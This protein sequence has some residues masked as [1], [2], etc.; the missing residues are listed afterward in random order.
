MSSSSSQFSECNGLYWDKK[1]EDFDSLVLKG[2]SGKDIKILS[3]PNFPPY[4]D[5]IL[6]NQKDWKR[7]FEKYEYP[8]N[9]GDGTFFGL[10]RSPDPL[11]LNGMQYKPHKS[12]VESLVDLW[13]KEMKVAQD[14]NKEILSKTMYSGSPIKAEAKDGTKMMPWDKEHYLHY[15]WKMAV[16]LMADIFDSCEGS[17][18]YYISD[19]LGSDACRILDGDD[20]DESLN[21]P[22]DAFKGRVFEGRSPGKPVTMES[23]IEALKKMYPSDG[24]QA[25]KPLNVQTYING[26]AGS[27]D[28]PPS[29]QPMPKQD[30]VPA[31]ASV[32]TGFNCSRCNNHNP[33][34]EANQANGT[35][36]CYECRS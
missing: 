20:D 19:R 35:Y 34:A 3:D 24:F 1:Y 21:D 31:K 27:N 28:D 22:F 17:S 33:D 11:R 8:T 10:D 2:H 7:S 16:D 30:F 13:D 5:G 29:T 36:L 6:L 32:K 26:W 18:H 9:V 25:W 12:E 4:T 14:K 23:F 15:K